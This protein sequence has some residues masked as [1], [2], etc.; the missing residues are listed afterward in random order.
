MS[1]ELRAGLFENGNWTVAVEQLTA[2]IGMTIGM[3]PASGALASG[4]LAELRIAQGHLEDAA[5]LL[6]KL[7]DRDE[8]VGAVALLHLE[9]GDV[10]VAAALAQRRLDAVEGDRLDLV[11]LVDILGRAEIALGHPER[12]AARSRA[13]VELGTANDC[14]L[15]VA[16]GERLFG[17]ALA[18][19]DPTEAAGTWNE[20]SPRSPVPRSRIGR[21]RRASPLRRRW[22]QPN[23]HLP[24]VKRG[25]RSPYSRTSAPVVTPTRPPLS[26][27]S[28]V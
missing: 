10:A 1:H 21:P 5:R 3:T 9:R 4:T 28:S 17:L 26:C 16:Y 12:A 11:P 7:Q 27:A 13:V 6:Q 19:T 22:R 2:G 15:I 25:R 14:D 23:D 18:G 8:V 20:R 24:S